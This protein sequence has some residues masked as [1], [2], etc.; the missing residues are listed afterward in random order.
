M[1]CR[2]ITRQELE[3]YISQAYIIDPDKC[4]RCKKCVSAKYLDGGCM[5]DKYLK[6]K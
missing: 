4:V 6:T 2:Q 5:M 3:R 1:R